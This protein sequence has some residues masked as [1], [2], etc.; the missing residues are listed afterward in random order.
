MGLRTGSVHE[1]Q[2][3]TD[4]L[5][6]EMQQIDI[7]IGDSAPGTPGD[8]EFN[9]AGKRATKRDT[10]F[11]R[12]FVPKLRTSGEE[13]FCEILAVI[14]VARCSGVEARSKAER[15]LDMRDSPRAPFARVLRVVL[16][17]A[18]RAGRRS[19]PVFICCSRRTRK[20]ERRPAHREG[21]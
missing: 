11:E 13:C 19:F 4:R 9:V 6:S 5:T 20:A 12:P 18:G 14:E 8:F 15:K 2:K 10:A 21:E 17:N 16:G 1:T 3:G 7:D